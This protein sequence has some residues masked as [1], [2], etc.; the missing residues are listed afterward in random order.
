MY[1]LS[2]TYVIEV[3]E[4]FLRSPLKMNTTY[5]DVKRYVDDKTAYVETDAID[6][7]LFE[8]AI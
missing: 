7:I 1:V 4:N 2:N 3:F 6:Y 5:V 8:H